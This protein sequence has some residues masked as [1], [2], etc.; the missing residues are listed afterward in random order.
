MLRNKKRLLLIL[1]SL[2]FLIFSALN[3]TAVVSPTKDFYVNDYANVLDDDT[4]SYILSNSAALSEKT[5]AQIVFVS[6]ES[7]EG[8]DLEEYVVE[9][10]RNW[11]IGDKNLNN[12]IL[13][14]LSVED[15]EIKIKVGNGLEGRINDS[16]VGRFLDEYAIPFFKNDDWNR[17]LKALYSAL[18]AE[19]YMEYGM[20]VP[21]EV[22]KVVSEC[23]STSQ[24]SEISMVMG[25]IIFALIFL[26]GGI[27]PLIY[28]RRY[29]FNDYHGPH[30]GHWGGFGGSGFGG[31]FRGGGFSGGGGTT[32]GG[33][34]SRKF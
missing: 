15:R 24:D 1:F 3:V 9:L 18:M 30:G 19:T 27:L 13:I 22:A 8:E 16:K 10:F 7:L 31:G 12:G 23:N 25:F 26:F 29:F 34:A 4:K 33:G 5:K 14:F 28:R 17:G 6:L 32:S 20:D 21:D 11:G 2:G